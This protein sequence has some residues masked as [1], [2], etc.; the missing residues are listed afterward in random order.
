MNAGPA[1][2]PGRGRAISDMMATMG[3]EQI[4]Y[5]YDDAAVLH[6]VIAIHST[7]LG[8]ALGGI[9]FWH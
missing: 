8:P 3:H 7:A 1:V 2:S 5:L 6:A 9:R 4:V